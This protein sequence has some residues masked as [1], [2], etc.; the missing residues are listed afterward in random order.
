LRQLL[1]SS[2]D[3]CCTPFTRVTVV[4][5]C[6]AIVS[7]LFA[8][9]RFHATASCTPT[10]STMSA[11][12]E[13]QATECEALCSIYG[14]DFLLRGCPVE[15]ASML[16]TTALAT[17]PEFNFSVRVCPPATP[18]HVSLTAVFT[19]PSSY[20]EVSPSLSFESEKGLDDDS[21]RELKTGAMRL[22]DDRKGEARCYEM[23]EWIR[24]WLGEHNEQSGEGSAYDE[25]MKRQRLKEKQTCTWP[26][27]Y[28]PMITL[29]TLVI[30]LQPQMLLACIVEMTTLP[31]QNQVEL[32]HP[33]N[34]QIHLH[35]SRMAHL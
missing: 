9:T 10:F 34:L 12:L 29:F 35:A 7:S 28:S 17:S 20:P 19:L 1:Q 32:Q 27:L 21:K 2:P 3:G 31:F 23:V 14:E 6:V 4:A 22:A 11:T 26:D 24:E 18:C 8:H 30:L 16:S 13:E 33:Q 25:M 5:L 15:A